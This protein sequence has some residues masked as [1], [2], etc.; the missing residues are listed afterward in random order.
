M[1]D[2]ENI[3][4]QESVNNDGATEDTSEETLPSQTEEDNT[5]EDSENAGEQGSQDDTTDRGTKKAKEPESR[6]YQELKNENADM[7]RLLSDPKSMKEYLRQLE[8]TEAPKEG[9]RD[10]L[11]E[12]IKA[13]TTSNG[14]I[15]AET[16]A[17]KLD[18]RTQQQIQKS[19]DTLSQNVDRRNQVLTSF[20]EEKADSR[21]D[22]PELDPKS[23]DFDPDLEQL[24]G[25]RFLAQGGLG[26]ASLRKVVDD[27]YAWLEKQRGSAKKEENTE[28]VRKRVGAIP[29][30]SVSGEDANSDENLTPQAILAKRII[31]KVSPN[32]QK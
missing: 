10:E 6:Y 26:R 19:M 15:D 32:A 20:N 7:R 5:S 28:I 1:D 4:N 29:Q 31:S 11:G 30:P 17:R 23:K 27:T 13:S 9:E 24:V 16:L 22:H 3:N 2:E 21:K 12:I 8:G 25:E 14:Q 18:E